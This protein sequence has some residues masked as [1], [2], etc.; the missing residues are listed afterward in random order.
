MCWV[1]VFVVGGCAAGSGEVHWLCEVACCGGASMVV[2][3]VRCCVVVVVGDVA[4]SA[5]WLG[6]CWCWCCG[7]VSCE[8]VWMWWLGPGGSLAECRWACVRRR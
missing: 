8:R 1:I 2:V 7:R 6:S 5:V 3:L 4:G